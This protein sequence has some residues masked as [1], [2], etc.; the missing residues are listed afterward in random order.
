VHDITGYCSNILLVLGQPT[1]IGIVDELL[2]KEELS[3]TDLFSEIHHRQSNTSRH[4]SIMYANGLVASRRRGH[5]TLYRLKHKDRVLELI[6]T[7][8]TLALVQWEK[9]KSSDPDATG[10]PPHFTEMLKN[11][12][13]LTRLKVVEALGEGKVLL[14]DLIAKVGGERTNTSHHL[15]HMMKAGLVETYREKGRSVYL[16]ANR[17]YVLQLVGTA[18]LIMA[19]E[20]RGRSL[21]LS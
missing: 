8:R 2:K 1:R 6:E 19:E 15:A 12:G 5:R 16:L 13:Q 21:L 14:E 17:N 7:A 9:E 11:L 10:E 18:K 20:T 3:V 4:L